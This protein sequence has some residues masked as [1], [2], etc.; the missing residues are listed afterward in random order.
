MAVA[1]LLRRYNSAVVTMTLIIRYKLM[2][3]RFETDYQKSLS[4]QSCPEEHTAHCHTIPRVSCSNILYDLDKLL[5]YKL[6][7]CNKKKIVSSCIFFH[8]IKVRQNLED[9]YLCCV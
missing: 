8:E 1:A 2:I 9:S 6:I 4:S 3:Q 5:D 7:H